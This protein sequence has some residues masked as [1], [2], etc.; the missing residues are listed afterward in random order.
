MVGG[1]ELMRTEG[2]LSLG[3]DAAAQALRL[4]DS[5]PA[6]AGK[7]VCVLDNKMTGLLAHEAFGHACE[8]DAVLAGASVLEGRVGQKVACSD[9]TLAD[10]PS[11]EA[12]FGY[13]SHD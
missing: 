10:D 11:I 3:T 8:A 9:V 2:A 13:F 6:P 5:K 1:Y 7:F 12:S 4:L